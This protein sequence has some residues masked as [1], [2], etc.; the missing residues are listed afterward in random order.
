M[1]RSAPSFQGWNCIPFHCLCLG[2]LNRSGQAHLE[3]HL[4]KDAVQAFVIG[5]RSCVSF[6]KESAPVCV[7]LPSRAALKRDPVVLAPEEPGC[8]TRTSLGGNQGSL[9]VASPSISSFP[10]R[11]M[12]A[13]R[14]PHSLV[15]AHRPHSSEQQRTETGACFPL[16]KN[17]SPFHRLPK[18]NFPHNSG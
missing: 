15:E 9:C 8:E 18:V 13:H 6:W 1:S 3:S 7:C 4:R 14:E 16:G 11:G 10:S 17:S 12:G 5:P 2:D